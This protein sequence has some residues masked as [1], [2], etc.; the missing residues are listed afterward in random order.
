MFSVDVIDIE[1]MHLHSGMQV[2]VETTH[3]R[4]LS[5]SIQVEHIAY[6]W[7]RFNAAIP[8]FSNHRS[9]TQSRRP[10]SIPLPYHV[11]HDTSPH[12]SS[13]TMEI[14]IPLPSVKTRLARVCP[15]YCHP[16]SQRL[17]C[18]L[19]SPTA[20]LHLPR[21]VGGITREQTQRCPHE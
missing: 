21:Y 1:Q 17:D 12:D 6:L 16:R 8:S 20:V 9:K 4:Q 15:Q 2:H 14:H 7:N 11:Y 18:A 10:P 5:L 13:S 3:F 19:P